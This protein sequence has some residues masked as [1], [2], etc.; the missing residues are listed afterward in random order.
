[1]LLMLV[2]HIH[3][4]FERFILEYRQTLNSNCYHLLLRHDY[5]VDLVLFKGGGGYQQIYLGSFDFEL[6]VD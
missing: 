2:N 3:P 6:A 1:M 4:K 5:C